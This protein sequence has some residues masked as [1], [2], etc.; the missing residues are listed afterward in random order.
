MAWYDDE[1]KVTYVAAFDNEKKASQ[2]ADRAARKGWLP[3]GT[4]ATDG[5]LNVG[6]TALKVFVLG[7]PWLITGASRT[8]GK[9]VITF[10]RS[11]EWLEARRQAA[12]T[13]AALVRRDPSVPLRPGSMGHVLQEVPAY[14]R[15]D[16]FVAPTGTLAAHSNFTILEVRGRFAY[17]RIGK[18][19][20]GWLNEEVVQVGEYVAPLPAPPSEKTCPRCAE[21]VKVAAEVCRYCGHNF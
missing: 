20:V 14:T 10:V 7:V 19:G 12:A 18:G 3:Q 8:K 11:P 4:A 1:S 16:I 5:H 17:V 15:P 6:R 21:N 13:R 2:E 9:I